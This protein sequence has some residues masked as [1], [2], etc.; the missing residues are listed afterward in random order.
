MNNLTIDLQ[1]F[2]LFTCMSITDS[3]S[4]NELVHESS[5]YC[6]VMMQFVYKQ[7]SFPC[8]FCLI[9]SLRNNS[10]NCPVFL[11]L[12]FAS[13]FVSLLHFPTLL[14]LVAI[15]PHLYIHLRT[16][17]S[18]EQAGYHLSGPYITTNYM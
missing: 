3:Y 14:V 15:L 17:T 10:F 4:K 9:L 6:Y 5:S 2:C 11:F 1:S 13:C 12:V 7:V 16:Y 8:L 18:V